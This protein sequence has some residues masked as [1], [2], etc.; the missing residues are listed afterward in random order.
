MSSDERDEGAGPGAEARR[1]ARSAA[2][3]ARRAARL[4]AAETKREARSHTAEVKRAARELKRAAGDV[5]RAAL[6]VK[7]AA[8]DVPAELIW[9]RPEPGAR[10]PRLTRDEIAAAALALADADGLEAV[11][12]RRVAGE[13]DV[14]T[15]TLYYYVETKDEL[16]ALM[17][18]AMMGELLVPD[19]ELPHRWRAA[20]ELISRRG[21][22]A[23]RRHPWALAGPPPA[24][25]GPNALRHVEQSLAAV[26]SLELELPAKLELITLVDDYVFGYA[27]RQLRDDFGLAQAGGVNSSVQALAD[28]IDAQLATGSF[29]HMQRI[30]NSQ[31]TRHALEQFIALGAD[32][33]RFERGLARVLDGIELALERR[34]DS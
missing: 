10:R 17:T 8:H 11:S 20:L 2:A 18:D 33:Q 13:L 7:R 26:D 21:L 3:E 31:G 34:P 25:L 12:M 6:D 27:L 1:A 23:F 16:F 24:P 30:V 5:K 22:E 28:Y 29:P 9:S 4:A 14:G 15:M 19:D 32:E